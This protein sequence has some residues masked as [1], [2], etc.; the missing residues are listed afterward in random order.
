MFDQ[1]LAAGIS[2]TKITHNVLTKA[3]VNIRGANKVNSQTFKFSNPN[4]FETPILQV[5]EVFEQ[6]LA[7]G[8]PPTDITCHVLIKA[9]V[10]KFQ[11]LNEN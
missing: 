10:R 8:I 5:Q 1:I 6:M 9:C 4:H 3:C 7:A 2:A 11:P